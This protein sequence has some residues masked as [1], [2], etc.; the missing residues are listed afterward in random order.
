MRQTFVGLECELRRRGYHVAVNETVVHNKTS[1]FWRVGKTSSFELRVSKNPIDD[2]VDSIQPQ[3]V[4]IMRYYAM[5]RPD[6]EKN[7]IEEIAR[8]SK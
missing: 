1:S 2:D 6:L 7:E 8:S 5:Y 3:H 4:A